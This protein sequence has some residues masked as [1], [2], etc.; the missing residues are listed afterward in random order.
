MFGNSKLYIQP[1]QNTTTMNWQQAMDYCDN[2]DSNGYTD[3]YLPSASQLMIIWEACTAQTKSNA[4]MNAAILATNSNFVSLVSDDYWSST[5]YGAGAAYTIGTV[6]GTIGLSD[7][8]D[9]GQVRCVRD[10]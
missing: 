4:C 10:Q 1:D 9:D 8:T 3:W 2:L 7:K 6:K 5:E